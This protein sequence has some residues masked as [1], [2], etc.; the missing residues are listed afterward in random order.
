[1]CGSCTWR[2]AKDLAQSRD[3]KDVEAGS[4]NI[5]CRIQGINHIRLPFRPECF[6]DDHSELNEIVKSHVPE[7]YDGRQRN[8][9]KALLSRSL[10]RSQDI[11]QYHCLRYRCYRIGDMKG[12][13]WHVDNPF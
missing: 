5:D 7:V 1:M 13:C 10:I 8:Y 11:K 9:A 12:Y 6:W 2:G 4:D 3:T